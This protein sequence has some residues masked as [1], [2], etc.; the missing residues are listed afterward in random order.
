ML[1][2]LEEYDTSNFHDTTNNTSRLTIPA[3]LGGIYRITGNMRLSG[4][5]TRAIPL[6][7][8]NGGIALALNDNAANAVN[9]GASLTADKLLVAGDYV[10]LSWYIVGATG[11]G[12]D[13]TN[14][15]PSFSIQK[16][17]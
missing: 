16:L 6:L 9:L 10:E 12:I 15:I 5:P 14:T 13:I 17:N 7:T 4:S 3:G 2:P 11:S 8:L 1:F